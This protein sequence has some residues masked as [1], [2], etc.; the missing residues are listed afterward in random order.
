M[1]ESEEAIR[2]LLD[3]GVPFDRDE[4]GC[5]RRSLEGGHSLKRILHVDGDATGKGIMTA[6][7]EDCA[8]RGN[9]HVFE[10]TFAIDLF[11]DESCCR[12]VLAEQDGRKVLFTAADCVLATGG[13]GQL[14]PSTTNSVV[15]TGDGEA[16]AD[17]AGAKLSSMEFVQFHPTALYTGRQ[18]E[19]AFLISEAVRGEGALLR[20]R[21]GERFMPQ[22][23]SR[24]ELAPRDVV[25]R[26]IYDQMQKTDTPY[27]YL[28]ITAKN[29]EF[30]RRRFPTI[31]QECEKNGTDLS[32]DWVPVAPCEHYFM[33][34]IR[35]DFA[36][37][38]NLK[39]LYAVGEC[40]CTGVHGANRLASNS[41]LEAVVFGKR[42]AEDIAGHPPLHPE[43]VRFHGTAGRGA[44][45]K[46]GNMK[47][48]RE[49]LRR[50]MADS[51][52]IVRRESALRA[53]R[54]KTESVL[55]T[56]EHA[57]LTT[58]D[59]FEAADMAETA[60]LIIRAAES[61]RRSIGSHYL[62]EESEY[63]GG[64]RHDQ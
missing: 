61:D 51:A 55:Q 57:S 3:L 7:F 50:L 2:S 59:E 38:T 62:L 19:R 60:D 37:R 4:N 36:G 17:R 58:R 47:V 15:L 63:S 56:F 40:A 64:V 20:N 18:E 5:F 26:A 24:L 8:G 12:G 11:T 43:P 21:D 16:M 10:N 6:L 30:L 29:R 41:L 13:I 45:E 42:A 23:D 1:D 28:D 54:E 14:Y 46:P 32:K 44:G 53:A 34:G 49:N 31:F 9:I 33:G 27:V 52:G 39:N 48:L 25:A 35:T 22:Y